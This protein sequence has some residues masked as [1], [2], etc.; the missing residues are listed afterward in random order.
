ML[1]ITDEDIDLLIHHYQGRKVAKLPVYDLRYLLR[2]GMMFIYGDKHFANGRISPCSEP[3]T[4]YDRHVCHGAQ[5]AHAPAVLAGTSSFLEVLDIKRLEKTSD[6]A[7]SSWAG[8]NLAVLTASSELHAYFKKELLFERSFSDCCALCATAD[9]IYLGSYSGDIV[10]FDP[11]GLTKATK[12]C[13]SAAVTGL[14]MENNSLLSSSADGS[15]FYKRKIKISDSAILAA[16][17]VDDNTFI[18]ACGDNSI[19]V[20]SRDA[21]RS[22]VGHTSKIMSL[23]YRRVCVSSS[24]D[25]SFGFLYNVHPSAEQSDFSFQMMDVG[26][27]QHKQMDRD[28]VL[29]YGLDRLSLLDLNRMEVGVSYEEASTSADVRESVVA[30]AVGSTINF[31][32]VRAS[33]RVE[34]AMHKSVSG[35]SFSACGDMLFASAAG[36][37]YILDLRYL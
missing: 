30:Y 35:L 22:Y 27:S 15:I 13:H 10:H 21:T 23:S 19:V 20:F 6:A 18:C 25:G 7:A 12:H 34:V 36:S 33:E 2:S 26:C 8:Y 11:V 16:R 14:W 17:Y 31:R 32:D 9:K 1:E 5:A 24:I 28:S 29:G 4:L 37:P 3:F